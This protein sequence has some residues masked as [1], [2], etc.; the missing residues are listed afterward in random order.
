MFAESEKK[1]PVQTQEYL[2]SKVFQLINLNSE[3]N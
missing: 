2:G 3:R 1:K